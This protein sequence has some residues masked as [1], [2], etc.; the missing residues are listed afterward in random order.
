MSNRIEINNSKKV[1]DNGGNKKKPA[2]ANRMVDSESDFDSKASPPHSAKENESDSSGQNS[3]NKH[4][5]SF[6]SSNQS[7][8]ID[9][10]EFL[11]E[12]KQSLDHFFYNVYEELGKAPYSM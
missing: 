8:S 1:I 12:K 10:Q 11:F 6:G 2:G 4:G 9:P 5:N 3:N 7:S